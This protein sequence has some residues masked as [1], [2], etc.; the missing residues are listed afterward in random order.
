MISPFLCCCNKD[1]RRTK[2]FSRFPPMD[3]KLLNVQSSGAGKNI[4]K[5]SYQRKQFYKWLLCKPYL[6][7]GS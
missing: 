5:N 3:L 6:L 1:P 7:L 2:R 4:N